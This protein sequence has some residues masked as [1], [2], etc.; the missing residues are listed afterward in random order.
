M[1]LDISVYKI[2]KRDRKAFHDWFGSSHWFIVTYLESIP[3]LAVTDYCNVHIT[4]KQ[5][6][7]FIEKC[8]DVLLCYYENTFDWDNAWIDI[9][10]EI[11]PIDKRDM[12]L[13]YGKGYIK[14]VSVAYES[15]LKLYEESYEDEKYCIYI[16]Y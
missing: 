5:V 6:K 2:D 10:K 14:S 16:S 9:A 11:L 3:N 13:N 8:R 15:F 7:T 12:N 4:R 1:G